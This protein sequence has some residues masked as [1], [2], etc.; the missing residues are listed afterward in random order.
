MTNI[1]DPNVNHWN[2]S[3]LGWLALASY[4]EFGCRTLDKLSDRFS[5]DGEAALRVDASTLAQLGIHAPTI[6]GFLKFRA[7]ADPH[8]LAARLNRD[9]ISFVLRG[10]PGY[11]PLLAQIA[12]P[13][14]ALFVRGAPLVPAGL[15]IAIVGTRRATPYGQRA[16]T[17]L[18]RELATAGAEIISGLALGIDTCAHTAALEGGGA[19]IA[20]LGTGCDDASVYPRAN[21]ALAA[22]IIAEGGT[23]ASEFPPGA[24]SLKHHFPL[25]NR[26]ISGL[27]RAT[28][29]IEAAGKSGSLITAHQALD[30][31]RDVF[32]VPGSIFSDQSFG[33]NRL[34]TMGAIPCTSAQDV[35]NHLNLPTEGLRRPVSPPDAEEQKLLDAM[36]GP[37]HAD[38]LARCLG[39]AS[40]IVTARLTTMELKGLVVKS[41]GNVYEKQRL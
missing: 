38:A 4:I 7:S 41:A 32:A 36:S 25:R 30:Q 20:I 15:R 31:N 16:A 33:T 39:L 35:L 23:V 26:I 37:T 3:R 8:A 1:F 2:P 9:G 40:P 28:I 17:E 5:G 29:V 10:D 22:R 13:P 27:A 24:E 6:D 11:P 19:C 21:A 18:A 12:D 14:H 34:L